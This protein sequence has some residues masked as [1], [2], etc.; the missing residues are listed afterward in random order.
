MGGLCHKRHDAERER[1][2]RNGALSLCF[3]FLLQ[4]DRVRPSL[5][6]LQ[7]ESNVER[8]RERGASE[9]GAFK[10]SAGILRKEREG[11]F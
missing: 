1:K 7:K 11:E 3:P 8:D 9:R 6:T 5:R 10:K 2:W 4:S